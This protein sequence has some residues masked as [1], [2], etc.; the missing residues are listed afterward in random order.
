ML[1]EAFKWFIGTASERATEESGHSHHR[2]VPRVHSG[3]DHQLSP[4][5]R[6]LLHP[7]LDQQV[8]SQTFVL[9]LTKV[10]YVGKVTGTWCSSVSLFIFFSSCLIL[11]IVERTYS[12]VS[13]MDLLKW[14]IY[15]SM[16]LIVWTDPIP[17]CL[18]S[19]HFG[20]LMELRNSTLLTDYYCSYEIVAE[21]HVRMVSK[22]FSSRWLDTNLTS[23]LKG[24]HGT[25][26]NSRCNTC[27]RL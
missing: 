25:T 27:K 24:A 23:T 13:K 6:P 10:I 3:W 22:V 12:S 21:R 16:F 2:L 18:V 17:Y 15:I 19:T 26:D 7:Q 14:Y 4:C 5:Y 1:T 8:R 9:S 20:I 11:W